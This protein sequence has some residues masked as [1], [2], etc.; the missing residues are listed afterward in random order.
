MTAVDQAVQYV[1][2]LFNVGHV[3]AYGRLVEH[4]ERVWRFL[5]ASRDVVSDFRQL[6]HEFD[7]LRLAA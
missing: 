4:V 1:D 2:E 6:G 3:Q 5:A 7:A